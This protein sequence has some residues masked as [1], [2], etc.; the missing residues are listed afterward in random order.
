VRSAD[1]VAF[2]FAISGSAADDSVG[3]V[4]NVIFQQTIT[5]SDPGALINFVRIPTICTPGN[6]GGTPPPSSRIEY[7]DPGTSSWVEYAGPS[8][9]YLVPDVPAAGIGQ[10][11]R[12]TCNKGTYTTGDA[13][14]LGTTVHIDGVATNGSSFA[15][16]AVL[17]A[18]DPNGAAIGVADGPLG[19]PDIN[20]SSRPEWDLRKGGFYRQDW[21]TADPDG[22]GPMQREAG[23]YTYYNI[24]IG[25][26]RKAGNEPLEQ[27]IVL[28][29]QLSFFDNAGN[30]VTLV[31]GVDYYVNPTCLDFTPAGLGAYAGQVI[32]RA[33]AVVNPYTTAQAAVNSGTCTFDNATGEITWSGIDFGGPYPTATTSGQSLASGPYLVANKWLR[34]WMPYSTLDNM[35]GDDPDNDAGSG[36]LW[37]RVDYTTTP[38]GVSGTPNYAGQPEPGDCDLSSPIDPTADPTPTGCDPLPA[39]DLLTGQAR[40]NNIA[41]PNSFTFSPG[42]WTKYLFKPNGNNRQY[43]LHTDMSAN[44]DGAGTVQPGEYTSTWLTW[45]SN[46][47]TYENPMQCDVWDR[48]MYELVTLAEANVG[49]VSGSPTPYATVTGANT[50]AAL[51]TFEFASIPIDY[52]TDGAGPDTGDDPLGGGFNPGTGR[53]GGTWSSQAAA[54]AAGCMPGAEDVTWVTDPTTLPGGAASA[55]AVRVSGP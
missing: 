18:V 48:T 6:G 9:G 16:E 24:M 7:W 44:H 41:G 38:L 3:S 31:A 2:N 27:P 25:A 52:D 50:N 15:S 30:P 33:S 43:L 14:T 46:S 35:F 34:V 1:N 40:S 39:P 36:W 4:A 22:A 10:P 54:V 13:A 51:L 47:R 21:T 45:V 49:A 8:T 11:L 37:N 12:L 29:D 19:G 20:I 55:N 42:T 17:F 32:S 23:F 53:Y 28:T 5:P 26:D